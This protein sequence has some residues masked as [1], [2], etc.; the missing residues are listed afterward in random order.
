M[1]NVRELKVH[2]NI[3]SVTLDYRRPCYNTYMTLHVVVAPSLKSCTGVVR[4]LAVDLDHL[5]E[6]APGLA[7]MLIT[8]MVPEHQEHLPSLVRPLYAK[9]LRRLCANDSLLA[10]HR[11][12]TDSSEGY[13]HSSAPRRYDI[14]SATLSQWHESPVIA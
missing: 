12:D 14:L 9:S 2:L 8:K 5:V 6:Y 10:E 7:E 1:G 4:V 11:R 13:E 3:S